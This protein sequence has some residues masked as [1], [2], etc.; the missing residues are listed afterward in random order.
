MAVRAFNLYGPQL[1]IVD[2]QVKG[3]ASLYV[4][5]AINYY[6]DDRHLVASR[7]KLQEIVLEQDLAQKVVSQVWG[8]RVIIAFISGYLLS[9][10]LDLLKYAL[11]G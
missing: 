9:H 1:R 7:D 8:K 2:R 11:F 6:H 3:K 4:R 5:R 10:A